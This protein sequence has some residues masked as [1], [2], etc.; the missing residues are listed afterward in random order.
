MR[1]RER[2]GSPDQYQHYATVRHSGYSPS[3][4][5]AEIARDEREMGVTISQRGK[6]IDGEKLPEYLSRHV[7]IYVSDDTRAVFDK[8]RGAENFQVLEEA[9]SDRPANDFEGRVRACTWNRREERNRRRQDAIIALGLTN[10]ARYYLKEAKRVFGSEKDRCLKEL[11][12]TGARLEKLGKP[13][14]ATQLRNSVKSQLDDALARENS[15][16]LSQ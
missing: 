9:V 3:T 16:C 14:S 12:G 7:V 6:D 11:N 8:V 15:L 1:T 4:V 10:R 13:L 2:E 5:L